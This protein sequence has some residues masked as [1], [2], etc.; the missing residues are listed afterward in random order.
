MIIRNSFADDLI[1]SVPC[2]NEAVALADNVQNILD[3]GDF[4]I[5]HWIMS[6]EHTTGLGSTVKLRPIQRR[7]SVYVGHQVAISF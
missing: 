2:P 7:F 3:Q 4:K 6:G 5:N 1:Q